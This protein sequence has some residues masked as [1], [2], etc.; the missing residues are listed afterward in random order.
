M[1]CLLVCLL[2]WPAS[3]VSME[4]KAQYS[5]ESIFSQTKYL[6]QVYLNELSED[7]RNHLS[8]DN[9]KNNST[10][11]KIV[12]REIAKKVIEHYIEKPNEH[13]VE[14][15]VE[16]M[17]D[18]QDASV[19]LQSI[20]VVDQTSAYATALGLLSDIERSS[21]VKEN[22]CNNESLGKVALEKL[23][24]AEFR[25]LKAYGLI[26]EE[27][28]EKIYIEKSVANRI[29]MFNNQYKNIS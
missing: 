28:D 13:S 7:K 10:P 17:I 26:N 8:P 25:L 9:Y 16:S 1:I 27:I 24:K 6:R 5:R 18:L 29:R 19:G 14:D 11:G 15:Y 12:M 4:K 22:Y 20:A 3:V 2:L 23:Y 21:M